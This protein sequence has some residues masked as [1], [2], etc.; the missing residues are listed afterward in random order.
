MPR[1]APEKPA[2]VTRVLPGAPSRTNGDMGAACLPTFSMKAALTAGAGELV[3]S[4]HWMS[5]SWGG[6]RIA[7]RP[8]SSA[9]EPPTER[10]RPPSLVLIWTWPWR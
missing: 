8:V 1:S 10:S 6:R 2:S 7:A 9:I 5:R 4:F 3:S